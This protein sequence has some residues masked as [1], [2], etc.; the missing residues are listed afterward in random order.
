M[1]APHDA[2]L[3]EA[4]AE[5]LYDEMRELEPNG[6]GATWPA[7]DLLPAHVKGLYRNFAA[8]PYAHLWRRPS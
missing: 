8:R 4:D 7:W 3:I 6:G 5:A 1:T 2:D